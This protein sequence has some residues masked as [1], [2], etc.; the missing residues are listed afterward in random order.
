MPAAT[1]LEA[2]RFRCVRHGNGP[3]DN[4]AVELLDHQPSAGL[5]RGH[6]PGERLLPLRHVQQHEPRVDEVERL[7][8]QRVG[9]DVVAA[10]LHMRR[11]A[12]GRSLHEAR[13][14][15]GDQHVS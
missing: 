14:H 2:R 11:P 7:L 9:A 8:G 13:V 6:Q 12:I 1:L 10:E 4:A 15:V 3:V 5:Q